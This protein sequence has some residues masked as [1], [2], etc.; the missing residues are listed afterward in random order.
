MLDPAFACAGDPDRVVVE[1]TNDF[2]N[3]RRCWRKNRAA[4]GLGHRAIRA[5]RLASRLGDPD[6]LDAANPPDPGSG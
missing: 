2:P 3:L 4:T 5:N 6:G 1:I